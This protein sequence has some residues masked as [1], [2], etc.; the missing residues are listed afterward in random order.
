MCGYFTLD[1]APKFHYNT[2]AA[3]HTKVCFDFHWY[4]CTNYNFEFRLDTGAQRS[5]YFKIELLLCT[6]AQLVLAKKRC[7][8]ARINE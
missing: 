5:T 2:G 8:K 6:G 4:A 3:R 7:V 1:N